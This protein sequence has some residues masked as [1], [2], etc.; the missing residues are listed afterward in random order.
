M[1][2]EP[3]S[4]AH[5]MALRELMKEIIDHQGLLP[6]FFWPEDLF[7]AELATAD[8]FCIFLEDKIIGFVLYRELSGAW[9]ISTLGCHPQYRRSGYMEKLI[10]HVIAAKG[11]ERELWLEVHESNLA[12]RQLYQKLG[13]KETGKRKHYYKDGGTAILFAHD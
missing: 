10:N 8:G 7:G 4:I 2:I 1:R 11:Q 6:E 13:F 3:Y 9:D 12:A 5:K